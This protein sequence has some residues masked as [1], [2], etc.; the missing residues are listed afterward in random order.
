MITYR[1][2]RFALCIFLLVAPLATVVAQ[3]SG[4]LKGDG[5][6]YLSAAYGVALPG[7]RQINED[8]MS[9]ELGIFGGRISVGYSILGF[10][11]EVS[12]GYRMATIKDSEGTGSI[13]TLDVIPS[14]YYD[15]DIGN[16]STLY[17]GF[18][19]GMSQVIVKQPDS[20]SVL[21][22][23]IQGTAGIGYE[24]TED[25]TLTLGYRLTGIMDAEFSEDHGGDT[26]KRAL[27]H[28]VEI[29]IRYYF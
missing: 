7:D 8:T 20:K 25:L 12:A 17:V 21:A 10:R 22:L 6:F 2:F 18:G 16:A 24:V 29:G 15:I 1:G 11:P 27:G 19:G 26:L 23:T 5:L 14:I 13:T 4:I 9:T 28:D 3:G